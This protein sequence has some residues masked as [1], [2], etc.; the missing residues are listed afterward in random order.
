ME[1]KKHLYDNLIA[2]LKMEIE[3]RDRKIVEDRTN[4]KK[5]KK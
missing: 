5:T 1:T 4:L 2:D 3:N